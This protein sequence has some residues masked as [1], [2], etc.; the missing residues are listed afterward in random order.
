MPGLGLQLRKNKEYINFK[1][2]KDEKG[3]KAEWRWLAQLAVAAIEHE[4]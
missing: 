4:S 3:K 2:K 1:K